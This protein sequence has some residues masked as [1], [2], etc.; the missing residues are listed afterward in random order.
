LTKKRKSILVIGL[1]GATFDLIDP[2]VAEGYL[3]NL[4]QLMSDGCSGCLASTLQPLSAPAWTTFMTGVNQGKHGV[5]D[6]VQRRRDSYKLEMTNASMIAVPTIFDLVGNSG[7]NVVSLNVPHTYPPH[8][9]NGIMVSGPFA[10]V[11]DARLIY[12][13][14]IGEKLMKLVDDYSVTPQYNARDS[15][16]L[17]AYLD[18]IKHGVELRY[19]IATHLINNEPWDLFV[20]VFGATDLVQHAFWHHMTVSENDKEATFRYAIREIYQRVDEAIGSL[21]EYIDENTVTIVMSDHGAGP[22]RRIVNLN[23]WLAEAGFLRFQ[24]SQERSGGRWQSKLIN[25]LVGVYHQL[26][27]V[28]RE[29]LRSGLAQRFQQL[30]GH[31]ETA[32]FTSAI[33]W[34]GT[35][36]YALGAGGKIYLNVAGREPEGTVQVGSEYESLRNE[37]AEALIDMEDPDTGQRIVSRVWRCE[38]LYHGSFLDQAPDLVVEWADYRY[39]G[40]GRYDIWAAPV[41]EDRRTMDFSDL[42]LTGTH[43]PDGIFIVNGP[44]VKPRV[45]IDEAQIVDL[46]PTILG[47]LELP[48][49]EYIDGKL[50]REAFFEEA[51]RNI[52]VIASPVQ[53]H[54]KQVLYTSEEAEEISRRLRDLGY[55]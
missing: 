30:K 12:P 43:R 14:L 13:P 16:P 32:L 18:A 47:L 51:F 20:V 50:L 48:I 52:D 34:S 3:P 17:C 2:W 35:K 10:P 40:R 4:G 38:E 15:D 24:S 29:K 37:I 5:Y 28:L 39:W 53:S 7:L 41:F 22:L 49:P 6:F 46:T 33:E 23:S 54:L 25:N 8:P 31:I 55:L 26:P 1:D 42:P 36:A 9:V 21:M 27:A 44:D 45:K 19:Q 11:S